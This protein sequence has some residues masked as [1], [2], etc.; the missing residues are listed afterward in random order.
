MPIGNRT[1]RLRVYGWLSM[2]HHIPD[3]VQPRAICAARSQVECA[4]L[5][6]RRK[7]RDLW[8]LCEAGNEHEI[9]AAMARPG[10][11]LYGDGR[12]PAT[13]E[14]RTEAEWIALAKARP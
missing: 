1:R 10:V 12:D 11:V 8:N 7:P 6:E 9:A 14:R 13:C 3:V 4:L 2:M 5:A